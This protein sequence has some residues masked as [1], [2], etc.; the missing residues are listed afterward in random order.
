MEAMEEPWDAAEMSIQARV[1]EY[2]SLLLRTC[3]PVKAEHECRRCG[4]WTHLA[5][6]DVQPIKSY[7]RRALSGCGPQ[8]RSK[9]PSNSC[10]S[11]KRHSL[12]GP[13]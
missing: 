1:R 6:F 9:M 12:T 8:A 11:P 13:E 3:P 10:A 7:C 2:P 4:A 5:A